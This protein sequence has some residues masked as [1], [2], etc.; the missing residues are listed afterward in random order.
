MHLKVDT[1][2]NRLGVPH[3]QL[4]EF[5]KALAKE[6]RLNVEGV[7]SHFAF[8]DDPGNPFIDTQLERFND[9]IERLGG[10]RHHARRSSTW[11]TRPLR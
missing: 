3:E 6:P 4:E 2:L 10:A 8:A 7:F 5:A 9:A 11:G 1:G